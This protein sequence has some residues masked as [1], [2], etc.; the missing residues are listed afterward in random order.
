MSIS[1]ATDLLEG[2]VMSDTFNVTA[3]W[4]QPSYTEGQTITG[5]I[6]GTNTHTEETVTQVGPVTV[7]LVAESG[8]TTTISLPQ[9]PVTHTVTTVEDVVIDV[10]V[11]EVNQGGRTWTVS[12]DLK[13]I[14]ATA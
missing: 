9:V 4:D 1:S 10:A 5:T 7:P 11:F 12:V 6:S 8:A 13:S 3:G 2:P 14:T